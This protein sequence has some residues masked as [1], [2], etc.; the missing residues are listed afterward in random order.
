MQIDGNHKARLF[1]LAGRQ[2][3]SRKES[4]YSKNAKDPAFSY[5][6][7]LLRIVARSGLNLA[8]IA[9]GAGLKAD[10]LKD[11]LTR[12]SPLSLQENNKLCA[13]L[14]L[15]EKFSALLNLKNKKL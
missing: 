15:S 6:K 13:F 4:T 3:V 12:G 14:G 7:L 2:R 1:T 9:E 5:K 11:A 8:Q 10:G